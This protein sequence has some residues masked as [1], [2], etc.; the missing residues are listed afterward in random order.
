[1]KSFISLALLLFS[2]SLLS[3]VTIIIDEVPSNTP[4]ADEIYIIGIFQNWESGDSDYKLTKESNGNYSIVLEGVTGNTF[5]KFNRG[6]SSSGESNEW[7]G[8]LPNR[9]HNVS[10]GDTLILQI[11]GWKD[12]SGGVSTA[13]ENVQ[14]LTDSFYM[15]T[16]DR[17]RRVWIYL[18]PDYDE[19][20]KDY[21]VLYM[22][23]GQ[24]IFDAT[25]PNIGE[26]KVDEILN[27]LFANGNEGIIV[28]GI[29]HGGVLDLQ[30]DEYS[31]WESIAGGGEGDQYADFLAF[32]LKPYIDQ[33]FRTIS[34][35]SHTGIM[36]SDLGGLISLYTGLKH[37][38]VFGK[39]GS[40]SPDYWINPQL[41]TYISELE[42]NNDFRIYQL[43]GS[44]EEIGHINSTYEIESQLE[45]VDVENRI[46]FLTEEFEDGQ[47][48]EWFWSREFG[49]AYL[50]LFGELTSSIN[51]APFKEMEVKIFPN[52]ATTTL[53]VAYNI[54]KQE[55]VFVYNSLGQLV[56]TVLLNPSSKSQTISTE[57]FVEGIYYCQL[58]N[59]NEKLIISH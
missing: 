39:I 27:D 46:D 57:S 9:E 30:V 31:P 59:Q 49:N 33:N 58:G 54:E 44:L 16:L 35:R 48:D 32:E 10:N 7:G 53:T 22:Q 29:D 40:F 41:N 4:E 45:S 28:V 37:Q 43:I 2:I 25:N 18:P 8:Y 55:T 17:Y 24:N 12:L 13:A 42:I 56:K 19:S 11:A 50:W 36:G 6:D 21:P 34:D 38:N 47:S 20:T 3:Q 1:M 51:E 14:V 15:S 23:N 5:F 26:W 52:P